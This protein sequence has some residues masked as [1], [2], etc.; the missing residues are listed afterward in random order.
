MVGLE[1]GQSGFGDIYAW[2]KRVLEFPLKEIV[3]KSD[4]LDEEMKERL[5]TEA[6]NRIIPALTAEAEKIP[7]EES[8]IIATDS[9]S[10]THLDV[11]KRQGILRS[12]VPLGQR[13]RSFR[14]PERLWTSLNRKKSDGR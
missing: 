8:T 3:G 12:T 10:Y 14:W 5:V 13:V 6:C 9:V 1:A 11:Y 4:L 7:A 2:F